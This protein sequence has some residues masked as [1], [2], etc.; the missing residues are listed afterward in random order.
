VIRRGGSDDSDAIGRVFVAARD[1]MTYLP[2]IPDDDRPHIGTL[3][4]RDHDELWVAEEG[5]EVVAFADLR[6]DELA[7]IYVD[8]AWQGR[9]LGTELFEQAKRERPNGFRWWVFQKND[10]AIRFYERHGAQLV[11]VTDGS[12]NM[13][14]EP[15][16][17]YAW[18][19]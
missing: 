5:G 18:R 17:L 1:E 10:G 8:P 7:H 14:R 15:D 4:T 19:P 3:I 11:N 2:R 6:D 9:G 13:E 12:D 16:A